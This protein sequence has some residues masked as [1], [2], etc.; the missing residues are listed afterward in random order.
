[1]IGLYVYFI[2]KKLYE[3]SEKYILK[4]RKFEETQTEIVLN[5]FQIKSMGME[6]YFSGK[7]DAD[8]KGYQQTYKRNQNVVLRFNMNINMLEIFFPIVLIIIYVYLWDIGLQP[9]G[10]MVVIYIL[11]SFFVKHE[12][13]TINSIINLVRLKP[14]FFHVIS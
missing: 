14:R 3:V 5:I 7:I 13:I 2:N 11:I 4:S 1:M 12:A 8:F 10:N 9:L 6:R